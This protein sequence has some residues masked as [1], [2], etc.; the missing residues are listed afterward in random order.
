MQWP[1][2]MSCETAPG[3]TTDAV[4]WPFPRDNPAA[5]EKCFR[6]HI[7]AGETNE[8]LPHRASNRTERFPPN[9]IAREGG[10]KSVLVQKSDWRTQCGLPKSPD[11]ELCSSPSAT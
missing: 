5:V 10:N 4:E 9:P 2:E 1:W 3:R 7:R 6:G 8:I 11:G